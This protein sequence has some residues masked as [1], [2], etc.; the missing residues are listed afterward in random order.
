MK[1][2]L[3]AALVLL[4]GVIAGATNLKEKQSEHLRKCSDCFIL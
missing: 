4:F 2:I 1:S 3:R